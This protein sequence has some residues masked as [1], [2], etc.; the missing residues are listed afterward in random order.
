MELNQNQYDY[1]SGLVEKRGN[2][3]G[4]TD[5]EQYDSYVNLIAYMND[6]NRSDYDRN[7]V[8]SQ[9]GGNW[10]DFVKLGSDEWRKNQQTV[11][12]QRLDN[13]K[14]ING[15]GAGVVKPQKLEPYK[16]AEN[17]DSVPQASPSSDLLA[18]YGNNYFELITFDK[19]LNNGKDNGR[20]TLA[21]VLKDIPAFNMKAT[22]EPGPA[23]TISDTVKKFMTSPIAEMTT[24]LGGRDRAWMNL[25]EGTDRVYKATSKPTFSLSFKLYTNENIGSKS[26]TNYR[27]W[28]KALSLYTMPSVDTKV[29]INAMA[30]NTLNGLYG[31]ADLIGDVVDA[32]K[33][34][35][36]GGEDG[37]QKDKDLIDKVTDAVTVAANT[38]SE[39]IQRRDGE[40]RVVSDANQKNFYGAKLWYL[41]ILPGIFKNPLIVYIDSWGVTYSKEINPDT[42]EPIWVEFN[43][44]CAMDQVASAP[45]WAKYL[46]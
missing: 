17:K 15:S 4:Y 28:I 3:M 8:I 42:L 45:T 37:K 26:L 20:V 10:S 39:I 16:F 34:A 21:G 36:Q 11:N 43:I 38:A 2:E 41:K 23:A 25:D 44:N 30:N 35:F 33:D 14:S 27:T 13:I 31:C 1:L 29:N 18:E 22:W 40:Y 12:Q 5:Q 7:N 19:G 9:L 32:A 46:N 6:N 24:T